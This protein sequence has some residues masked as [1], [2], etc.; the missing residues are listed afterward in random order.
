MSIVRDLKID[1]TTGDLVVESGDLVLVSDLAAI[2]QS[3]RT[4]LRFYRGEWFADL[5]V[6]VPWYETIFV[7]NPNLVAVRAALQSTV[8]GTKGIVEVLTFNLTLDPVTR[9]ASV[10]FSA[11][12]DTGELL[13]FDEKFAPTPEVT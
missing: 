5:D 2:S 3:V 6:G 8:A 13:T 1:V 7:K 12:A 11:R 9:T 4:R 10:A